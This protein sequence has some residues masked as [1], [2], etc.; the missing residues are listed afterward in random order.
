MTSKERHMAVLEGRMPDR[1][2]IA[3]RMWA[4][5]L[6]Q[7]KTHLEIKKEIDYDPI[8]W[9]DCGFPYHFS[10]TYEHME[11]AGKS[12]YLRNVSLEIKNEKKAGD[13]KTYVQRI[14]HTPAGMLREIMAVPDR[15]DR[16]Y[17]I[18]PNPHLVEPLIKDRSDMEKAR[19]LMIERKHFPEPHFLKT[20][21]E[22][23]EEGI[24]HHRICAGVDDM[25]VNSLGL[26]NAL[27]LYYDDRELLVDILDMFHSYYKE[28]LVHT[29]ENGA[30]IIFEAWFN[31]SLSAGWSPSMYRELFLERIRED[32]KIVHSYGG[33]LHFYDDGKI[34]PVAGDLAGTGMDMITTLCPPPAGDVDAEEIKKI[35]GGRVVL[36]GYV[37]CVKMRYGTPDETAGQTRHAC[38]VLGKGGGYI[39]GTSDSI[40]DGTPVENIRAFFETGLKY[41]KYR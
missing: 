12:G 38:E 5:L 9:T 19:Y 2:P 21:E 24:V 16:A 26:V 35:M 33:Y 3:P 4:W 25:L 23:G 40:R 11:K 30:R 28:Q 17:G 32:V 34:M 29:L 41:G 27:M 14:F 10:E 36:S 15:S 13:G 8:I 7:G 20:V 22:V 1:I 37:D 31:S 18:M 6:E 39:L